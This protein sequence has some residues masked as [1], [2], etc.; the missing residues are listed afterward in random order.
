MNYLRVKNSNSDAKTKYSSKDSSTSSET[1]SSNPLSPF[2]IKRDLQ[3][4]S[5]STAS[6]I[7]RRSTPKRDTKTSNNNYDF[8]CISPIQS[9]ESELS[10]DSDHNNNYLACLSPLQNQS[11]TEQTSTGTSDDEVFD[12]KEIELVMQQSNCNRVKAEWFLK[13]YKGDTVDAIT[14]EFK[15]NG[16]IHYYDTTATEF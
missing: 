6:I 1:T 9:S 14:T 8:A 2:K 7:N 11:S 16:I 4:S 15:M 10:S 13:K 3:A 5:T 12:E